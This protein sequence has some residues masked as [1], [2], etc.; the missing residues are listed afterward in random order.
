[1]IEEKRHIIK[2]GRDYLDYRKKVA[3]FFPFLYAEVKGKLNKIIYILI[4]SLIILFI[5]NLIF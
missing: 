2:F 4:F 3:F 5:L 1:M